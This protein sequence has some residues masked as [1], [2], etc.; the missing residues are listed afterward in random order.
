MIDPKKYPIL[1]E[2]GQLYTTDVIVLADA[3]GNEPVT[4]IEVMQDFLRIV[5]DPIIAGGFAV[6]H[7]GLVR[8]TVDIDVIS[9]SSRADEIRELCKLGYKQETVSLPVG[10]IDLLTKGNKG[11][12]FL[13][14]NDSAFLKSISERAVP[15]LIL[16]EA[17]KMVSIED[18]ILLKLLALKGRIS[19]KDEMDLDHLLTLP[20]DQAYL[21]KWKAHLGV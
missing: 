18:L 21:T 10:Q 6:A 13:H 9:I 2:A 11:I 14:L 7:H 12:D 5:R 1:K 20:A 15:G 3:V 17:V 4:L 16:N 8:G 19:K